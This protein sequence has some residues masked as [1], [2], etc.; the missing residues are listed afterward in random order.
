MALFGPPNVEKLKSKKDIK[1]L[2]KAMQYDKNISIPFSARRAL[3]DLADPASFPPL[4]DLL[5]QNLDPDLR[6]NVIDCL[7]G[8]KVAEVVPYFISILEELDIST[9][10]GHVIDALGDI[11][12]PRAIDILAKIYIDRDK[13]YTEKAM[14]ALKAIGGQ[15]AEQAIESAISIKKKKIEEKELKSIIPQLMSRSFFDQKRAYEKI[16]SLAE[17]GTID[18]SKQVIDPL[19]SMLNNKDTRENAARYLAKFGDMKAIPPLLALLNNKDSDARIAAADALGELGDQR[20]TAPLI[21]LSL[22]KDEH[23]RMAAAEALGKI[24]GPGAVEALLVVLK[25]EDRVGASWERNRIPFL[26]Q[27]A[28]GALAKLGDPKAVP[29]IIKLLKDPYEKVQIHAKVA[30]GSFDTPE[31][32][33]ALK[34]KTSGFEKPFEIDGEFAEYRFRQTSLGNPLD[35]KVRTERICIYCTHLSDPNLRDPAHPRGIAE[36]SNYSSGK[37]VVAFDDTCELWAPNY[38]VRYWLSKGYMLHNQDGWP[39]TPWYQVFD[40][41]PD[42]EKGTR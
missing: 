30:L 8:L 36:C 5:N 40:D 16:Q 28:L 1:G 11:G 33:K 42:G 6:S 26:R 4:M 3:I 7:G 17:A 29:H 37:S 39:R 38:K 13:Y 10:H 14:N 20:A 9:M 12:D 41:G 27:V 23:I 15:K 25:D 22:E 18:I 35:L 19:I 31:A 34:P 21:K 24:G 2:I 32:K